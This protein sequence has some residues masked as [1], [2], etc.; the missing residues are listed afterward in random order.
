MKKVL[1]LLLLFL[2][3]TAF[4]QTIT[5][6]DGSGP[7]QAADIDQQEGTTFY[8]GTFDASADIW[9]GRESD[10]KFYI[11]ELYEEG[12]PDQLLCS[13][14]YPTFPF[15]WDAPFVPETVNITDEEIYAGT[16][17]E[18]TQLYPGKTYY[19]QV[20]A[21]ALQ[22]GEV[23]FPVA[24]GQSD[25]V[26]ILGGEPGPEGGGGTLSLSATPSSLTF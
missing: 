4:G 26:L 17:G 9:Y 7:N 2:P 5:V 10:Q 3:L 22:G 18:Y 23:F 24:T 14:N 19:L 20:T 25:G 15:P 13:N 16:E 6:W 8:E 11:Y 12:S 1:P 21:I